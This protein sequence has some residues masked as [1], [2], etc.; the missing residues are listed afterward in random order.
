MYCYNLGHK[1]DACPEKKHAKE[2]VKYCIACGKPGHNSS[3]CHVSS[4]NDCFFCGNQKHTYKQ[5][6]EREKIVFERDGKKMESTLICRNCGAVGHSSRECKEPSQ[7]RQVCMRCGAVGHIT[8][9]CPQ[10][11]E[12]SSSFIVCLHCGEIGHKAADC[13]V[14]SI[15][16]PNVCPL[17]GQIGHTKEECTADMPKTEEA[18]KEPVKEDSRRKKAI[19]ASDLKD[20]EQFPSL[21]G[22][23]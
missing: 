13:K 7:R 22:E 19:T 8:S 15:V 11:A 6:P 5:C 10:P 12:D 16:R 3:E 18:V 4:V 20:T 2:Y 14:P 1:S 21:S 23:Q 9:G 17:C